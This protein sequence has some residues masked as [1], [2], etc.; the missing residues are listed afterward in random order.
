L[1]LRKVHGKRRE[2]AKERNRRELLT[3]GGKNGKT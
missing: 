1:G 2:R 3:R